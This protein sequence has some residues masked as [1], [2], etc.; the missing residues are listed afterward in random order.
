MDLELYNSEIHCKTISAISGEHSEDIPH[1]SEQFKIPILR[2]FIADDEIQE[3]TVV[4]TNIGFVRTFRK[5]YRKQPET[6]TRVMKL[7]QITA[8]HFTA[9]VEIGADGRV[10]RAAPIVGWLTG[11]LFAD[12]IPYFRKKGWAYRYLQP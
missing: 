2:E 6:E 7:V 10:T 11:K 3:I 4:S 9:G 5:Y 8:K 1:T 12:H